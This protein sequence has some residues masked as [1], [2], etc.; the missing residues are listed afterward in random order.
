MASAST[1]HTALLRLRC[2]LATENFELKTKQLR[3][4]IQAKFNSGQPRDDRGRWT[5]DGGQSGN[6][7]GEQPIMSVA[8]RRVSPS[9]RA[10]CETQYQLDLIECRLV[11]LPNC[12]RQAMAR[13]AAC[14]HGDPIPPL[15]Y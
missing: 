10:M 11:A 7:S 8:A 14:Q 15:N 6:T 9:V 5:S 3:R 1:M 12:Y 2:A 4:A 13:L